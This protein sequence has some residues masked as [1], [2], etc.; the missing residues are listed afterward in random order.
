MWVG[1]HEILVD[2]RNTG[3][4]VAT[5]E[6]IYIYNKSAPG[7]SEVVEKTTSIPPSTHVTVRLEGLAMTLTGNTSYLIRATTSTGAFYEYAAISGTIP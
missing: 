4:V 7:V 2:L 5:L 6:S 3:G 1:E